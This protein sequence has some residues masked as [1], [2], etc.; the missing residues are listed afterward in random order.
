M[1]S[2]EEQKEAENAKK[3]KKE[4]KKKEK[5]ENK[6]SG[7]DDSDSSDSSDVS[8][9]IELDSDHQL[10]I[11]SAKNLMVS[12]STAVILELSKLLYYI[13]PI[14]DAR[15]TI[16]V[17][18]SHMH[19]RREMSYVVLA[20]IATMANKRPDLFVTFYKDFYVR[21]TE[22]V[23]IK[24]LKLDILSKIATEANINNILREFSAYARDTDIAFRCATI[25]AMG[26][27]ASSIPEVADQTMRQLMVCP[28]VCVRAC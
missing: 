9:G 25:E 7:D 5:K 16:K 1:K 12:M 4:K 21:A 18:I 24:E 8:D 14:D 6:E 17:L 28:F 27:C 13:A 2:E 22:P 26:R 23:F 19:D 15:E 20:N 11:D 10:L 3:E